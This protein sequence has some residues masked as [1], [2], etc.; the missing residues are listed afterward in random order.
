MAHSA[1]MPHRRIRWNSVFLK[2]AGIIWISAMLFTA[3]VSWHYTRANMA[4][5]E[6]QR[7]SAP[8][9]RR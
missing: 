7:R 9:P 5:V 6:A 3:V 8:N 2:L 1:T 4:S